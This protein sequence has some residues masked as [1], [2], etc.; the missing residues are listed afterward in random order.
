MIG[1]GFVTLQIQIL[2]TAWIFLLGRIINLFV[3]VSLNFQFTE[4]ISYHNI[5]IYRIM[6]M[7]A[8]FLLFLRN[9]TDIDLSIT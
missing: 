5:Y 2:Y 4:N 1:N 3:H 9:S 8:Y 7:F 6:K